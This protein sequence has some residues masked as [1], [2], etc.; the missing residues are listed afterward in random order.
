MKVRTNHASVS[1][2]GSVTIECYY[3]TKYFQ[4]SFIFGGE[5]T[6]NSQSGKKA[7]KPVEQKWCSFCGSKTGQNPDVRGKVRSECANRAGLLL[8]AHASARQMIDI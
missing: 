7:L 1:T 8:L 5:R 2:V 6:V 3:H 4:L